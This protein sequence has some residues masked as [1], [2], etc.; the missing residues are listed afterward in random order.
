MV[1]II[2]PV[3]NLGEERGFEIM[4]AFI[5][6]IIVVRI[7]FEKMMELNKHFKDKAK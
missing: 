6:T 2:M 4:I 1:G 5:V 7:I 3:F